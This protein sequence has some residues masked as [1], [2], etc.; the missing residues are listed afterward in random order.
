MDYGIKGRV[1]LVTGA[2]GAIGGAV[3]RAL[4]AEGALV[5]AGWHEREPAADGL[6]VRIDQR[7]PQSITEAVEQVEQSYGPIEILVANAVVWPE[8]APDTWESM[9]AGLTANTVG[10]LALVETVLPALRPR[11]WGRIVLISS[12]VVGQPVPASP[13]YPAAKSA[14]EAAARVLAL[15]ES[16]HGILT[17]V[18]RPGF[19]LTKRAV[20]MFGQAAVDAE[21]AKTPTRRLCTPDDVAATVAYLCSAANASV[22]GEVLAVTGG[23]H[24]TR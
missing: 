12:D 17:N 20:A 7:D 22:N 21:A 4:T 3:A 2:S 9:V 19:T 5:A 6:T 18:V 13:I 16:E 10:P 8:W 11:G 23:R 1:A 14:L 15:R 24:L